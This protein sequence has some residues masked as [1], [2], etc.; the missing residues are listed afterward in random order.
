MVRPTLHLTQ[1]NVCLLKVAAPTS[2]KKHFFFGLFRAT[3]MAYGGSQVEAEC[4]LQL[5][6]STIATATQ[7][8]SHICDLLYSSWQRQTSNPLSKARDQT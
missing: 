1:Q 6:A 5:L 4:K 7:G 3:Y 8:L 2:L